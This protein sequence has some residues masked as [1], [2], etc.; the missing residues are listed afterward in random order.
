M[1]RP[2][3]RRLESSYSRLLNPVGESRLQSTIAIVA[4]AAITAVVLGAFFRAIGAD[5][6]Q[7]FRGMFV[8]SVGSMAGLGQ[9]FLV[10]SPLILTGLAAAIPFSARIFNVGGDGQ[11]VAGAVTA[12]A[13]GFWLS[14]LPPLPVVV[15]ALMGGLLGGGLWG[16][17]AGILKAFA[18]AN[19]VVV[20]LML[21]FVAFALASYAIRGPWADPVVPQT[22][23]LPTGVTL[24]TI[25]PQAGVNIGIV[26]ALLAAV[27]GMVILRRTRLGLGIRATGFNKDAARSSGFSVKSVTISTLTIG[28]AFAG[29]AGAI[30][31]VG[32]YQALVTNISPNYGFTGIAI[33]LVAGLRP[34]WIVPTGFLFAAVTVGS[35][36]L[37]AAV[38]VSTS[39]SFLVLAV[40]VLILMALRFVRM[41]YPETR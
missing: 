2:W 29:L 9:T 13:V 4:A 33:A 39:V 15:L 14:F 8:G 5:P 31:V 36:A 32:T 37:P 22:R 11:L 21:N 20:T 18:Q 38:D 16:A 3:L 7:A 28:G 27:A 35:N 1:S 23:P 19:E 26:L 6:S 25:W 41:S 30:L 34:L 40:F 10:T 12:T 24:P 17:I